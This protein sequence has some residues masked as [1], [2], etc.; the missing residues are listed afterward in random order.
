MQTIIFWIFALY[1]GIECF[2]AFYKMHWGDKFCRL[3]KYSFA[4]SVGLLGVVFNVLMLSNP[5]C[6][7]WLVPDI[8]ISLFLWPTTYSR[9]AG[10]F[11]NR[12]GD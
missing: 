1:I 2:V 4:C 9:F 8:A 11:E 6:L 5:I 10:K 12:M 3:A 7:I